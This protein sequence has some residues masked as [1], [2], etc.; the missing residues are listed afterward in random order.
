[1]SELPIACTL[2]PDDLA[3]RR[4]ELL[5][6]LIRRARSQELIDN[7]YRYTFVASGECLTAIATMIDAERQCCRFLRFQLTV[8]SNDGPLCLDV[9]GPPGTQ[10][11]LS[12]SFR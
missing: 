1:M 8:E 9:T 6:G 2:L 4:A 5:P 7:G 12:A 11:F 3:R 10:E